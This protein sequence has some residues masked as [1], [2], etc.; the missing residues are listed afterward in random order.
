MRRLRTLS[1]ALLAVIATAAAAGAATLPT[2]FTETRLASGLSNPTAMALAPDGRIFICQQGGQ[3]RVVKSGALLSAPFLSLSVDSSG[4]RG[5]LGVAFDPAFATNRF[6]YVYY[7]VPTAPIHNRVSRFIA[8]AANPDVVQAG[9][10]VPLLDLPTLSATNHNGGAIHF[11][12]DGKLYIAVGENANGS[13]APLLTTPLGKILRINSDGTIPADNPF[14]NQTTGINQSIWA[15]G[16][17]NPFTFAIQPGTGRIHINDVGESTWEEVDLGTAGA[18]YGWPS[19]EGPNPPGQAGVTYP[20]YFYSH[21]G[22]NCA[23]VGAAFYNPATAN[24]PAD[25]GGRY[26]FGDLCGGFI[27]MLSP[28]DYT[29]ATG[30]ATGI[31]SLVDIAVGAD[32]SLY[33]LARGGGELFRVQLSANALPQVTQQPQD[34]TVAVGQPAT[35]QVTASGIAPLRYQWQRDMVDIPGAT[36]AT[37]TLPAA[38]LA[39]DGAVFRVVVTNDFGSA[40]SDGATL[41]VTPNPPV[42]VFADD[43]ETDLGWTTNPDGTDTATAGRW[44]R[45]SPMPTRFFGA[46]LQL[47]TGA[48]GSANCLATGLAA[49]FWAGRNDLDNGTTSIESPA[50]TL[51]P[52]GTLTLSFAFYFSHLRNASSDDFFRASVVGPSGATAVFQ[53]LGTAQLVPAAWATRSVDISGFA[54]QTIRIR[55]EAADS[56]GSSLIEAGVDDVSIVAR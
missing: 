26:F 2:G 8:S 44:E 5:L 42:T 21:A 3:L 39:D 29:Q 7:T 31:S 11:G 38:A 32:G 41:T 12:L 28:P 16:L 46:S 9:S 40:T 55:F 35:F 14:F 54:G 20:I 30:F 37:F 36:S 49:G 27:R 6:I 10:E 1:P 19:V 24:F 15:R 13:N 45:G 4:E 48:G 50:I 23:I 18:N 17:R 43:F 33:Y 34:V 53:E 25:F 47:G 56:G 51:P 22:G 52:S